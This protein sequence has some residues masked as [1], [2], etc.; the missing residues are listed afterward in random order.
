MPVQ[1]GGA[2]QAAWWVLVT[3]G[4]VSAGIACLSNPCLHGICIDDVNTTYSCYCVDG[5]TGVQCQTNW[6]ECWSDPCQNGG[7]CIDG[8]AAYNCSCPDGFIGDN[9]E[10]NYNECE[11]NPC[12]NNGT[13]ID[14]TNGYVCSCV[15]GFSG[16]HCEVDIAVCNATEEVRCYNGGQCIEGPGFKFYCKCAAGWAGSKCEYQ[17]D[18]CQSMP[19][20]NGGFCIDAH[21]DYM[22]ACAYGYTGKDCEVQIEFCNEDS[23]SDNAICVLEDGMRVCYCVPDFHGERCELQYDECLL[24]PRCMNGGTCIDG[25]DNF[26]CSCPPKLTGSLCECLVLDDGSHDCEYVSPTPY[27]DLSSTSITIA[28][29]FTTTEAV[30]YVPG[31][32]ETTLKT[33]TKYEG[34]ESWT[35]TTFS[36]L[37]TTSA[38][39]TGSEGITDQ[40]EVVTDTEDTNVPKTTTGKGEITESTETVT[41]ERATI[42]SGDSKV[43]TTTAGTQSGEQTTESTTKLTPV[44]VE[45]TTNMVTEG[46]KTTTEDSSE[47]TLPTLPPIIDTGTTTSESSI[48]TTQSTSTTSTAV[49]ITTSKMDTTTEKMFTDTPTEHAVTDLP[50]PS[51][52]PETPDTTAV[53]PGITTVSPGFDNTTSSYTTIQ[54]ECTD[55]ICNN[56]GT[57][58][59]TPHGITTML[60]GEINTFVNKGYPMKIETRLDLFVQ[61]QH[62]NATLRLNDTVAMSGGQ[63]ANI[64]ILDDN[65]TIHLGNKPD[66]KDPEV[67]PF[68]G[69]ITDLVINGEK[70]EIFGDA[71]DAGAVT[72]C[73]SLSCLSGPCHN[74]GTCKDAGEG[75][76]CSCANGWLGTY[77]NQSIC[78][79]NPCKSG[80]SCVPHPGSGFLCLCPYG[81]HGLFCEYNVD[82]T[83]PSFSPIISGISSY[84]IFPLSPSAMNSDRFDLRLRFQTPDMDQIALLAFVGNAPSS[85]S[86]INLLPYIYIGGHSSENF[87][88][89]PHDLPLHSG[90]KG[91]IWEVSGQ[92]IGSGKAIGGRGVG[93]C[94]VAQCTSKSCNAPRGVCIHS[95]ATYGCICNEGW[96]GPTCSAKKSP[97]D[98]SVTKCKGRC[99]I[100]ADIAQCDCPY[101]KTGLN[102]D[103]DLMPTDVLFTGI[104][105]YVKLQSRPISSVSLSLEA[106]VKPQKERGLVLF[107]QT[108][109][110]YTSLSL[111]GGM[112]EFRWTDHL[113][114]L[115]SLVRSGVVLTTSHWHKVKAGRY[116]SRLY[117][118]ADGSLSTESMLAHAYPHTQANATILVGGAKDLA[119]LPFDVMSG[120]PE[121][122]TGCIRNLN[123]NNVLVPLEKHNILEGQNLGDCDGTPCGSET[124]GGGACVVEDGRA[125]CACALSTE[126]TSG[127]SRCRRHVEC[128]TANCRAPNGVCRHG[129]CVCA[130]GYA[131][132]TCEHRI[133]V[134]IPQFNGDSLL[135]VWRAPS[136]G[137]AGKQRLGP[138]TRPSCI[139][140]NFT[141]A[142]PSGL[143]L[144]ADMGMDYIGIG[145]ENG[146]LKTVWYF[147]QDNSTIE[148][149][150]TRSPKFPETARFLSRLLPH[151]GFIADAEW[152]TVELR[153]QRRNIT[154]S[155]DGVLAYMEEPGLMPEPDYGDIDLF[156]GGIS[157]EDSAMAKKIFSD[158]FKGCIDNISTE[159]DSYI[160]NYI[161][162]YSENVKSCQLFP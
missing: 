49:D 93:Q 105:S 131:G 112:L 135:S 123:I 58:I 66:A 77:C 162:V 121:S 124:C 89:L 80:G 57:C 133:N 11:S 34:T 73:S 41:S 21:A 145:I 84:L 52:I 59:N 81:K 28:D 70:R 98:Q 18:E 152:H 87:H 111:Q 113:S 115:T 97:C 20:Q 122:F 95:P 1:R 69:C 65:T 147:H 102:C 160:T 94:G 19:C 75:Y 7:T 143:L 48:A 144:W 39:E 71:K 110:F 30:T 63:V 134:T 74:G 25:V 118:W 24:G 108:P 35:G 16:E 156:I 104:R 46:V 141:T 54:S 140:L 161:D 27:P 85:D 146:Y 6:D 31:F 68:I 8:I 23:C 92:A 55:S 138:V 32:N 128:T 88:D 12:T 91:C 22:C 154:I 148:V 117:V 116:G 114:G 26:T 50:S 158:N 107:T 96:F 99:V 33:T 72:E 130:A 61:E 67:K 47:T 109:H 60:L 64:S 42:E 155:V 3:A 157:K 4:A 76:I 142:Q 13:C 37:I 10:T 103:Q 149:F 126:G 17:I 45:T 119:S 15:P 44:D 90:W 150:N 132:D 40:S 5:Y 127:G 136:L 38:T 101:G 159:E 43:E 29:D 9:C 106:E 83:R 139:A 153:F 151:A 125:R 79:N 14:M 56:R 2:L 36:G 62:C 51:A 86:K 137:H 82:I 53:S 100:T 129:A 120:P 78:E